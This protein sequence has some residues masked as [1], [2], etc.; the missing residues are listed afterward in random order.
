[1]TGKIESGEPVRAIPEPLPQYKLA[2]AQPRIL[3]VLPA[4]Q[5]FQRGRLERNVEHVCAIAHR[6]RIEHSARW[7]AFPEFSI[8][9]WSPR[10]SLADVLSSTVD[11]HGS[12]MAAIAACAARERIYVSLTIHERHPAF[13]GRYFMTAVTMN[14]AGVM[15]HVYRKLY[16]QTHKTRPGDVFD[17]YVREF[18]EE[19]FF[20]VTETPLGRIGTLIAGDIFWPENA[21]CLALRGAEVILNPTG[22][23]AT[24]PDQSP[25]LEWVRPVRAWENA[26]YVAA[27]NIGSFEDAEGAFES[28]RPS[29]AFD[30]DGHRIA[31]STDLRDSLTVATIDLGALRRARTTPGRNLLAQLQPALHAPSYAA[32]EVFPLNAW[33]DRRL[34]DAAENVELE[35]VVLERLASDR[36][37]FQAYRRRQSSRPR[38]RFEG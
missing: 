21:R 7:V 24:R 16:V 32:A 6:A 18:G 29:E 35:R 10:R 14:D 4:D 22:A 3:P 38:G 9:G 11:L 20:P 15:C 13:P 27:P 33:S 8:Q 37:A 23:E 36:H 2:L 31:S 1:M 25:A 34:E 17:A 28:R 30:F 12:E 26:V 19:S 5:P